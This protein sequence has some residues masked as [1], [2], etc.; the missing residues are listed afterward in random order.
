MRELEDLFDVLAVEDA[1]DPTHD[2]NVHGLLGHRLSSITQPA[3][4]RALSRTRSEIEA[5]QA[6]VQRSRGRGRADT[7]AYRAHAAIPHRRA[8]SAA[9]HGPSPED[10]NETMFRSRKFG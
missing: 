7:E 3:D 6:F 8:K 1:Q 4:R 9:R 2:L 10:P 5:M